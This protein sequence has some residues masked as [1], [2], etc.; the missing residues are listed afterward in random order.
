MS[1]P[2]FEKRF[3]DY[4]CSEELEDLINTFMRKH[5]EFVCSESE[6]SGNLADGE[7]SLDVH[8]IWK[9]YLKMIE[10]GMV[11]FQKSERLTDRE[12]KDSIEDVSDRAPMLVKLMLASWE[13]GQ[14]IEVCKVSVL[15][16]E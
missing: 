8:E 13:F 6:S 4:L 1:K 14:F 2:G 16:Y 7:Y 10:M 12:L 5:A 15:T 3:R 9:E 11:N